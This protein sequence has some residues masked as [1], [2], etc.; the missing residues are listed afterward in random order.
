MPSE[1]E[2]GRG[3]EGAGERGREKEGGGEGERGREG[4]EGESEREGGRGRREGERGGGGRERELVCV[5]VRDQDSHFLKSEEAMIVA[6]FADGNH[7]FCRQ[8]EVEYLC[9]VIQGTFIA[10][11]AIEW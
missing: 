3:R 9:T 4:R 1:S 7:V 8:R 10:T 5:S 2:R 6:Q 11:C